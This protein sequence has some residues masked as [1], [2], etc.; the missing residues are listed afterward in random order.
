MARLKLTT[1]LQAYRIALNTSICL[2]LATK[3]RLPVL[4]A[5]N[6]PQQNESN[7]ISS[8]DLTQKTWEQQQ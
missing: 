6:K 4:I 7:W 5:V 2:L 8:L 1:M 3:L